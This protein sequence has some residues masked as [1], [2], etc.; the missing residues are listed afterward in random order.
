MG[1]RALCRSAAALALVAGV[2]AA[3]PAGGT[4]R[5]SADSCTPRSGDVRFQAS[6]GT[7][8]V[9]HRFGT[10]RTAVILAHEYRGWLCEWVPFAKRLAA[11]CY[12]ALPFDFRGYGESQSGGA[13]STRL[14]L[15]VE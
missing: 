2:V 9:G 7:H 1:A 15:D 3:T 13:R 5:T 4:A 14:D 6:D 10:G 11:S 12:L 8:L